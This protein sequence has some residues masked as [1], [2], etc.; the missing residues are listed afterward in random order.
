MN[1]TL[2][3]LYSHFENFLSSAIPSS[4]RL[5]FLG[6]GTPFFLFFLYLN[7]DAAR[8]LFVEM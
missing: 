8:A 2:L 7:P 6:L 4:T 1:N 5:I 3:F